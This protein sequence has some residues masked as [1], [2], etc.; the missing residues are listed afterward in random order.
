[1]SQF[2]LINICSSL[3]MSRQCPYL[4]AMQLNCLDRYTD[5]GLAGKDLS[6]FTLGRVDVRSK[7][8]YWRILR[9]GYSPDQSRTMM[10]ALHNQGVMKKTATLLHDRNPNVN[11][12]QV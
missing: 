8:T 2:V 6:R 11:E 7:T 9:V 12:A 1:M 5:I 4:A 3:S 10:F